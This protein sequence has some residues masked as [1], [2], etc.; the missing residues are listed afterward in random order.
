MLSPG[1]AIQTPEELNLLVEIYVSTDHA[2]EALQIL[3]SPSLGPLSNF[4]EKDPQLVLRL[5]LQILKV[6]DDQEMAVSVCTS[7]LMDARYS[8]FNCINNE[9]LWRMLIQNSGVSSKEQ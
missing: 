2:K 5:L 7:L 3:Q 8:T 4:A 1:K 9:L 6:I